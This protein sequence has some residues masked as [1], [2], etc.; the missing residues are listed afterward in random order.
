ML[1]EPATAPTPGLAISEIAVAASIYDEI[2]ARDRI[3]DAEVDEMAA[4]IAK[5]IVAN[6]ATALCQSDLVAVVPKGHYLELDL[7]ADGRAWLLSAIEPM[8][9]GKLHEQRTSGA[10]AELRDR[11]SMGLVG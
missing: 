10:L 2:R 1:A 11:L 6:V 4:Q 9:R 7:T 5:A 8:V 3:V